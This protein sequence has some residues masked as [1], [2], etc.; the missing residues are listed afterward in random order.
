MKIPDRFERMLAKNCM[1]SDEWRAYMIPAQRVLDMLR[2]E[3]RWVV[4]MVKDEK[5]SGATGTEGDIAYNQ[6]LD[7]VLDQLKKRAT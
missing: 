4:Q 6:A 7:D 3:P 1:Q 5:V 2:R